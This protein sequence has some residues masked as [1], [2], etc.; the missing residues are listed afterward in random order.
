M[1]IFS[2]PVESVDG[3]T[4]IVGKTNSNTIKVCY[5]NRVACSSGNVMVLPVATNKIQLIELPQEFKKLG[6][7]VQDNY[8]DLFV[9]KPKSFSHTNS[10]EN[11]VKII[12]Y[13]PYDVSLVINKDLQ[14]VDWDKFG[15]LID[16]KRF[17]NL[18]NGKYPNHSFIIA[19]ISKETAMNDD[20][21]HYYK[22]LRDDSGKNKDKNP[23]C[24]EYIPNS[25]STVL[26][27]FHIHNGIPES[28]PDWNH[29][30]L[31]INGHVKKLTS[32]DLNEKQLAINFSLVNKYLNCVKHEDLKYISFSRI[33]SI[34][35]P[36]IDV[37]VVFDIKAI[38]PTKKLGSYEFEVPDKNNKQDDG[39]MLRKFY[40]MIF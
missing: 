11:S 30:I 4:I 38:N 29:Y 36:N 35:F 2:A 14:N 37:E 20:L 40:S 33:N 5:A 26:P 21:L 34:D 7:H 8:D 39:S 6:R 1:C 23:I 25:E 18:L 31:V 17:L 24:Y 22:T 15:G 3:T 19:K 16:K 12:K 10:S 32:K 13:G 28:S 9:R 27:T